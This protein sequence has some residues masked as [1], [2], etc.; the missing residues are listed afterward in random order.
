MSFFVLDNFIYTLGCGPPHS[1]SGKWRFIDIPYYPYKKC[2][3]PGGHC[4]YEGATPNTYLLFAA[5]IDGP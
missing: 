3:N 5:L 1:N 4:Y 2:N